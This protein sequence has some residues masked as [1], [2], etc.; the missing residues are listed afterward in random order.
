MFNLYQNL[1]FLT[2]TRLLTEP[3]RPYLEDPSNEVDLLPGQRELK[4]A[5]VQRVP[6][7]ANSPKSRR[8]AQDTLGPRAL[9]VQEAQHVLD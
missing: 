6:Q 2:F 3:A 7:L 9:V 8:L 4:V 5:A 1:Y